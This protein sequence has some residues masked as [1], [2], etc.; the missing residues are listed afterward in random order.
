[1]DYGKYKYEQGKKEKQ[2]KKHKVATRVKEVKY[3]ANVAEHDYQ[4]KLRHCR[5]FLEAG[6]RVKVSLWFRGREGAHR[7]FGYAVLN[8]V[9]E[10][11]QDLANVEQTPQLFGRNLIMR[12]TPRP[13]GGAKKE[14]APE[15]APD[16]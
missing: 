5:S 4:T 13:G 15:K 7:E 12:L 9:I 6:H 10:D 1:M 16:A 8:R 14:E 2:A 3:H 11:C